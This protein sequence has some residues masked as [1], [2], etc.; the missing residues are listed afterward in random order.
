MTFIRLA[1]PNDAPSVRKIY[2]PIVEHSPTSFELE[3]PG[4]SEVVSRI[5]RIL[6][7]APWLIAEDGGE[8]L[9]YAYAAGFRTRPA[10]AWSMESSVYVADAHRRRGVARG[11]YVALFD[12][13]RLQGFH[14]LAAGITL[15]NPASI[16]M[17]ESMGFR[18]VGV[19]ERT[20]Y[21]F[22]QWHAV[23]FWELCL[24]EL[25]DEVRPPRALEDVTSETAFA[26]AL[27]RGAVRIRAQSGTRGAAT[28]RSPAVD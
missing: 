12:I 20:G 18:P 1:T 4:E 28:Q 15:P 23:G 5:E 9:G 7:R 22:G 17:H 24:Q 27:A 21:K 13:L 6:E 25:D 3:V 8:C 11:L 2:R 16:A 14:M 19:F 26:D 10:Y